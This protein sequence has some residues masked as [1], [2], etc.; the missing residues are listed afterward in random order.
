MDSRILENSYGYTK[1]QYV[2][3]ASLYIK[4]KHF[5]HFGTNDN[6]LILENLDKIIRTRKTDGTTINIS[7]FPLLLDVKRVCD[8]Y[9]R[10]IE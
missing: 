5:Q 7:F 3:E 8:T 10:I 9:A 2:D 6:N 4:N 1:Q